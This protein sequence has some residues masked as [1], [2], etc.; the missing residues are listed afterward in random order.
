MALALS[1]K[2]PDLFELAVDGN[3]SNKKWVLAV[4]LNPGGPVGGSGMQ[5][6][7][8]S[9]NAATGVYTR[10]LIHRLRSSG[11][12]TEPIIMRLSRMTACRTAAALRS[13]G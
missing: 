7:V 6:F 11:W 13:A 2:C 5:Y 8:G 10:M 9:F 12:I 3:P 4:S 1:G